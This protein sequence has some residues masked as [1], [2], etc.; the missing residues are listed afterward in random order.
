M[1]G[2]VKIEAND[3]YLILF[4]PTSASL[5]IPFRLVVVAPFEL[6]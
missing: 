3:N 2:G 5:K 4:I 1:I 6:N